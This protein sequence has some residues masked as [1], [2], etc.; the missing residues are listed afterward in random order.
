M[1]S[2]IPIRVQ[3]LYAGYGSAQ[4]LHGVTFDLTAG[5]CLVVLGPNGVGKTTLMKAITGTIPH[6]GGSIEVFGDDVTKHS[7]TKRLRHIGW[8][9]EG[10]QLFTEMTVIDTLRLSARA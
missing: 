3:D 6:L 8:V 5:M 9:P 7:S 10:R 2:R 4:V 1:T